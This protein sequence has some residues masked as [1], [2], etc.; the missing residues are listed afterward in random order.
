VFANPESLEDAEGDQEE[1]EAE[2]EEGNS[3]EE[4]HVNGTK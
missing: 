1:G 2:E 3:V 4:A